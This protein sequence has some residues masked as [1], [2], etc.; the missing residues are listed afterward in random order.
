MVVLG[1]PGQD[2]PKALE[3][4]NKVNNLGNSFTNNF[5]EQLNNE[6][7]GELPF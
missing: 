2:Y 4:Y 6:L 7:Y 1:Y 5:I 3:L